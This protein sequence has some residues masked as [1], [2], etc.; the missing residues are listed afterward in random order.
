MNCW[1]DNDAF[2]KFMQFEKLK[3]LSIFNVSYD[4][5]DYEEG[6]APLLLIIGH[7]LENL[8]LSKFKS[9]DLLSK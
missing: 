5:L 8:I 9:V 3:T 4:A 6:I 7:T 2:Y 1:I